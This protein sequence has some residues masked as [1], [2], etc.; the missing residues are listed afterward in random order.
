MYDL[1]GYLLLRRVIANRCVV[2]GHHSNLC[3]RG[4]IASFS[5]S[6]GARMRRFLRTCDAEYTTLITLTYPAEY[7][8]DGRTCKDQL[9]FLLA[10]L[11]R[12]AASEK[13]SAFWFVEFQ[14]RGAPH[15]HIFTTHRFDKDELSAAWYGIVG[16]GDERHLRAGTRIEALRSGRW[17][18]ASYAAKY[19]SKQCQ[20]MI[21]DN[22]LRC[23]RFW[24]V[25]GLRRCASATIIIPFYYQH[26]PKYVAFLQRLRNILKDNKKKIRI[27]GLKGISSGI[28]IRDFEV[29]RQIRDL[30]YEFAAFD[31]EMIA[32]EAPLM[33]TG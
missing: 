27:L 10:R 7:P 9:R 8:S 21:P 16:S 13:F 19:A 6:A 31:T 12:S 18:T 32:F 20:K 22:F 26:N 28:V 1:Q 29:V 30:I 14:E 33:M 25:V 2:D 15:F 17:G 5:P 11:S 4:S 3:N 23:G 24:G